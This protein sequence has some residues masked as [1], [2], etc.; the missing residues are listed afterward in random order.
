LLAGRN[1]YPWLD[2]DIRENVQQVLPYREYTMKEAEGIVSQA[3]FRVT[4]SRYIV[5]TK[6][7]TAVSPM[8]SS[9]VRTYLMGK[10]YNTVQKL[11]PQLRSHVMITA[12]KRNESE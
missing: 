1:I 7:V 12:E 3:G 2:E 6:P 11:V 8:A 5:G 9:L 4:G 10:L